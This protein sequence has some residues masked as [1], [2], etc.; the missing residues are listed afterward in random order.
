MVAAFYIKS[1]DSLSH[2][3]SQPTSL[4]LILNNKFVYIQSVK[5]LKKRHIR[6]GIETQ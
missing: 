1:K 2:K 5:F 6:N 3:N 4:L